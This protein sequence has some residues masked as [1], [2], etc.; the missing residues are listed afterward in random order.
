MPRGASEDIAHEQVTDHR[1]QILYTSPRSSHLAAM[2]NATLEPIGQEKASGRELGLAYAQLAH[3]GN[4]ESGEKALALLRKAEALEGTTAKDAELHTED[5]FLAQ[6][7][8]DFQTADR[9]YRAALA[10]D[11]NDGTAR[12][13]LAVLFAEVGDFTTAVRLWQNVFDADP[14]QT[15]AGYNLALGQCKLGHKDDA[16]TTLKR[17][18]SFAPDD[19]HARKL[20]A[21][22]AA[23]TQ[24][25]GI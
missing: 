11:P 16:E 14:A 24:Q 22:L 17:L 23:G 3:H 12:G 9:E 1:I 6:M 20:A 8:G 4:R 18:V 2:D 15:A 7:A 19:Q 25:C 13:D 5:G 10:A 21:A